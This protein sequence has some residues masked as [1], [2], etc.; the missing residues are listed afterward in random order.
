MIWNNTQTHGHTF[1]REWAE[2]RECTWFL[3]CALCIH[4]QHATTWINIS[5]AA[6]HTLDAARIIY[7]FNA[8]NVTHMRSEYNIV[9][10]VISARIYLSIT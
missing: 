3:V 4:R 6:I 5:D 1:S 10:R 8:E 9:Y 2:P 7:D